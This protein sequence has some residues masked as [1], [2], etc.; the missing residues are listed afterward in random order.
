MS[1]DPCPR[2]T[3]G[4]LVSDLGLPILHERLMPVG[5]AGCATPLGPPSLS[6]AGQDTPLSG[7]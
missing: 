5:P 3:Y 6:Q 7:L 1:P 4:L 2:Q